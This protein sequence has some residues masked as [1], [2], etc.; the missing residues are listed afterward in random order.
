MTQIKMPPTKPGR[1]STGRIIDL[2]RGEGFSPEGVDVSEQM[3]RLAKKR[4]PDIALYHDDICE[5]TNK[6]TYDLISAWDSIWHIPLDQQE[7][8][9]TK[10]VSW[11]NPTGV[12]IFSFGGADQSGDHIDDFMGPNLYYS[13]LGVDGFLNVFLRLGCI[14]RHLEYDQYPEL[15]AYLIVQKS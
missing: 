8:V 2:L 10:L 1:F 4:H 12:L 5:W 9:L 6:E 15:H 11:L 3:I 7:A 13:T 14:C